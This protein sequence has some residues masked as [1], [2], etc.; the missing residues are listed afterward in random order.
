MT[1]TLKYP[2]FEAVLSVGFP[3]LIPFSFLN[4]SEIPSF[5]IHP[6]NLPSYW[7]PD[8]IRN[9][10][11]KGASHFG[12]SLHYHAKDFDTGEV[13]FQ[14]SLENDNSMCVNEILYRLGILI[15]PCFLVIYYKKI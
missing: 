3:W 13:I 10:I 8:P 1:K 7:G 2:D 12:V 6:S 14:R 15:I 11:I 9:Q 5:N 4:E